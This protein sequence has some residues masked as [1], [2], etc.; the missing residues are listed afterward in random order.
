MQFRKFGNLDFKASALGFGCMRLPVLDANPAHVNEP[1]AVDMI[2]HAVDQGVNY[3]DTAHVYHGGNSERVL[4]RALQGRREKVKIATKFPTWAVKTSADFDRLLNEQLERL[5]V[6]QIDFYLLHN[7]QAPFW[8]KVR[9]LGVLPWLDRIKADGRVAHVGFSFHDSYDLFTEVLA[10]YD[11]W[12]MCQVQYNYMN[13]HVQAGTRGVLEAARRGLAVVVMEPLMGGCLVRVPEPVQA[14]FDAAAS[15]RAPVD[16]ALQWLWHRP[17]VSVVLSGMSA[18]EH[19][20]ENVR[21]ACVSGVGSLS[22]EDLRV[23]ARV[24]QAYEALRVVPCTQCGYCMPCSTGVDIPRNMQLYSDA[25][26]FKGNQLA[27]NRNIYNCMPEKAR[28]G[29]CSAC[30][31]CEEKCPQNIKVSELMPKIHAQFRR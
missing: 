19:V 3:F 2:R 7:L 1:L 22:P 28:A 21:S 30:R 12:T 23:V 8:V 20:V 25:L 31:E 24:Q 4:G 15:R 29:A 17:Q 5:Q 10:A 6:Q 11:D 18:M 9:D 13:E 16:W 14:L 26:V 27:L